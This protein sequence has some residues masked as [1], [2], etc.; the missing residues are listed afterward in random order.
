M[1][2]EI[3]QFLVLSTLNQLSIEI[4]KWCY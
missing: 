1:K 4:S 3:Y 2:Q